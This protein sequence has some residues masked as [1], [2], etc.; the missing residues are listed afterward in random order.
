[1]IRLEVYPHVGVTVL[2]N[3][4]IDQYMPVANG[5]FVKVYLYLL[6]NLNRP[7][8]EFSLEVMADSLQNTEKD[9]YRA[10][11]YWEKA[12]LLSLSY[13]EGKKLAGIRL[14]PLAGQEAPEAFAEPS[15]PAYVK[16][17]EADLAQEA[18]TGSVPAAAA[19]TADSSA[20]VQPKAVSLTPARIRELKQNED[21]I[22]LLYIAEQYL[23]KTLTP[24]EIKK[25]L[26]LY[27]HLQMSSDLIEYLIEYCV[28][29]N[30]KSIRYI[31]TVALAWNEDGIRTVE[32][33]K[34]RSSKYRKDYYTILNAMG[35]RGRQP[36]AEE[37]AYMEA[38]LSENGFSMEII[39]EACS[40]TVMN[41]GQASFPYTDGILKDWKSK[42]V[43]SLADVR[44]LDLE[45]QKKKAAGTRTARN[46][47]SAQNQFN[48]FQQRKYDF[49]EYE[50]RLLNQ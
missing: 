47:R 19:E 15:D 18:Q 41:T 13:D 27:D 9:I 22:Q 20:F 11:T 29:H 30:H 2:S 45:H 8:P 49:Q 40:R 25:L 39:L 24:S 34:E 35:I 12:K 10:L 50:K 33:A 37:A 21:V 17:A 5:E 32:E 1:M 23:G 28:V 6:R 44:A 16:P 7:D 42:Q 14:N 4:F 26:Y 46:N 31:E 38:W 3:V 43:H 36:V 48:N